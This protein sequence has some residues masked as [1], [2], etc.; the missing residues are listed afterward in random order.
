M[1]VGVFV[2]FYVPYRRAGSETMLHEMVKALQKRGHEVQVITTVLPEAPPF[3][4][5]EGVKVRS[6]NVVYGQQ[7]MGEFQP[8]VIVTHHENTQWCVRMKRKWGIPYVFIMHNDLPGTPD[9]LQWGPDLTVFN[10]DWIARKFRSR[11]PRSMVLH[12]PVYADQHKA[13]PGECITLVNLN[14]NKGSDLFYELAEMMPDQKFLGVV[15]GHGEQIVREDLP[16]VE[17]V[18][19][20][21]D[22]KNDVWSRTKVLLMPSIYESYGMAG[23]EAMASGIPVIAHPTPGLLESLGKAGTFLDRDHAKSW[24]VTLREVL[25]P[26][27]YAELSETAA[28]RSKQLDPGPELEAWVDELERLVA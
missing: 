26:R 13:S 6:T 22:M 10:T 20:T 1:K 17:I 9:Q 5:Y 15:G 8:D 27:T 23:V 3:Y 21:S 7:L 2:H 11:V 25:K 12:P 4:E 16:N 28:K 14:R 24:E 18:Q 19:H